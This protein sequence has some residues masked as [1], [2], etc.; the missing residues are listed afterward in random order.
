MMDGVRHRIH[1]LAA[2]GRCR[3]AVSRIGIGNLVPCFDRPV[4]RKRGEKAGG[5][6]EIP[7]HL[8]REKPLHLQAGIPLAPVIVDLGFVDRFEQ[9]LE[10]F[11]AVPVMR[12]H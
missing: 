1:D 9:Q 2:D 8:E 6:A 4:G 3:T 12:P 5:V 11:Q 7:R 10:M